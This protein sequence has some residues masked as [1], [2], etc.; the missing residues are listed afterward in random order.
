MKLLSRLRT[1]KQL[2][3]RNCATVAAH[4][5]KMRSGAYELQ[6]PI[7]RCPMPEGVAGPIPSLSFLSRPWLDASREA[8]SQMPTLC[9]PVT[10]LWFGH[11]AHEI[12]SPPDWFSI[13][14]LA[15]IFLMALTIGVV[16]HP[17]AM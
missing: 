17:M 16:A 9:W 5:F 10:P 7:N 4:R 1:S 14:P 13:P 15:S 3:W 6:L 8:C 2:G 11:E 12:G